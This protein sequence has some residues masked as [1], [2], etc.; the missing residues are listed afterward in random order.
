[1]DSGTGEMATD[2]AFLKDRVETLFDTTFDQRD[3]RIVP[4]TSDVVLK[5]G[6]VK[7]EA[8][9]LY[10]D[11]AGSAKL[12]NVCP[13]TTTAKVI[14]AFLDCAT[15]LIIKHGGQVRSFDGDR[16][17][18]VFLGDTKNNSASICGRE[19]H[20]AVRKIIHPAA[21]KKFKSIADSGIEIRN[22]SGVD[23]GEVRAV[24][25]GIRESNDLI[26]IGKAASF[27][28]KLSD[29]RH[30]GYHTYISSRTYNKLSNSAKL[31]SD[32]KNMWVSTSFMFAGDNETVYK[33]NHWKMP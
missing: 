7:V 29:L 26:W 24:R 15:R 8:A 9:F 1:M 3:G 2:E 4:S 10:T 21:A 18:G 30:D 19:I 11:L 28:A 14:R 32:G 20:W 27:A 25:S 12:S 16:V 5:D 22:C 17:M 33:S 31:A 6:A 23:V 13:W